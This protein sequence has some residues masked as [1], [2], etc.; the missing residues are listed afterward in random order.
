MKIKH[1]STKFEYFTPLM[2]LCLIAY[3]LIKDMNYHSAKFYVY[4]LIIL[5]LVNY[6]VTVKK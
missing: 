2:Q 5:F 6:I 3:T 1:F 4:V